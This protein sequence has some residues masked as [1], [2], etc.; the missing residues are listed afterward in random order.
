MSKLAGL[1]LLLLVSFIYTDKVFS[2]VRK[3]DPLMQQVISYKNKHDTS[4]VEPKIRDDEIVLGLS[5]LVIDEEKSYKNMKDDDVFNED[6][7]VYEEQLPSKTITNNYDY[8][9]TGGNPKNNYVSIIFKV[10]SSKNLN[11]LINQIKKDNVK[12]NI[13][14]DG[15]FLEENV[16]KTFDL[17]DLN[18]EIYNL[19]YN[20]KYDKSMIGVTNNLIESITLKDS[21][22]CL[23]EN[24]D[25][26]Q[27]EICKNKKMHTITPTIINPTITELKENLSKGL[28]I[29]YNLEDYDFSIF[30]LMINTIESRGYEIVGLSELIKELF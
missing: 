22:L 4:A 18:S 10:Q 9:I 5:G 28:M 11:N 3:N 29:S 25:D 13:F 20:G 30:K 14:I 8:Y 24:K 2:E 17:T 6:K 7:I 23:N 26:N 27:K 19:G 21:N 1:F 15:V 16:E 12:I